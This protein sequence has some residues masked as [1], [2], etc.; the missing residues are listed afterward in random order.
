MLKKQLFIKEFIKF[1]SMFKLIVKLI[2]FTNK[3]M[4]KIIR[5]TTKV[6]KNYDTF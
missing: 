6:K 5:F 2:I 4:N 1:I 3:L